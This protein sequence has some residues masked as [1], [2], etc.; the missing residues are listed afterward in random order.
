M[1]RLI[2]HSHVALCENGSHL[3]LYGDQ[4]VYFRLSAEVVPPLTVRRSRP[5]PDHLMMSLR[6]PGV[7]YL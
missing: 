6:P 7:E 5:N 4:Q 2:P 3:S 1:G